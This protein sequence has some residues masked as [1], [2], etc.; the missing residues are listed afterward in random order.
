L[1]QGSII[2]RV[3]TSDAYLPLKNAAVIYTK[4]DNSGSEELL[5]ILWTDSSGLT[6]P[7]FL[8]TP[9]LERSLTPNNELLP[10]ET[11]NIRVSYPG[12]NAVTALGVQVFPDVQTI[13]G[14][15]LRPIPPSEDNNSTTI[16]ETRQNL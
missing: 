14:F 8:E 16:P 13:Q 11:I 10:Y 5:S 15:H 4:N 7:F 1:P 3:Y 9:D 12:Y 6:K 2:T